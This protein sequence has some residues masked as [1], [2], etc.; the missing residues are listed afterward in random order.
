MPAEQLKHERALAE[1]VVLEDSKSQEWSTA[2]RLFL[3]RIQL[4]ECAL[5]F[6]KLQSSLAE[7]AVGCQAL[8]VDK[9][10]GGFGNER[11]EIRCGLGV[12]GGG[13]CASQRFRRH[14]GASQRRGRSAKKG[15]H[16]RFEG[17]PV[18]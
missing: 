6:F 4:V 10:F 8:V 2:A 7:L 9:V 18:A 3:A 11:V 15:R 5:Q 1:F 16:R 14:C 17:G 12:C 13:R